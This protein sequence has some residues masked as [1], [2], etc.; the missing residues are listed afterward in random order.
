MVIGPNRSLDQIIA[1]LYSLSGERTREELVSPAL[2]AQLERTNLHNANL[3]RVGGT[4]NE[5]LSKALYLQKAI[6]PDDT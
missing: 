2:G 6:Q 5:Q 4:T 3:K 1:L